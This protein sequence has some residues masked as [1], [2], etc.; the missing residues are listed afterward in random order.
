MTF[1][2]SWGGICACLLPCPNAVHHLQRP[3][4]HAQ[5][6]TR[7]SSVSLWSRF[8]SRA[9]VPF[10][11]NGPAGPGLPAH[12]VGP[13]EPV[14]AEE[15]DIKLTLAQ[16]EPAACRVR[17]LAFSQ[18]SVGCRHSPS[19]SSYDPEM[20]FYISI[21]EVKKQACRVGGRFK[22][23]PT[24]LCIQ[25]TCP[26]LKATVF[27]AVKSVSFYPWPWTPC[28]PTFPEPKFLS[29]M[30]PDTNHQK[31]IN[32]KHNELS[33]HTCQSGYYQTANKKCWGMWIKR[34]SLCSRDVNWYSH[35]WEH[36]GG[37]S[38]S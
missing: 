37:L 5:L 25:C 9:I 7:W 29:E 10:W 14:A 35:Y 8:S 4:F 31:N 17:A 2:S 11:P 30:T 12:P 27:M 21:L 20:C 13:G 22:P 34:E 33:P 16:E 18:R 15:M 36:Y 3:A 23:R 19:R 26:C 32:Q 6:F 1:S 24:W 38:E 28:P